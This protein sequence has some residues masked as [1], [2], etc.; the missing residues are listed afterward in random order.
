LNPDTLTHTSAIAEAADVPNAHRWQ[1]V[2][3][4]EKGWSE[5]K[6][7]HLVLEGGEQQLLRISDHTA[8]ESKKKAYE[9]LCR[10]QNF[11]LPISKP[12]AFGRCNAGQ[13]VYL[14]FSWLIGEEAET[15]I[16]LLSVA[17]QYRLGYE[18][19]KALFKMH[20]LPIK[21]QL[22]NWEDKFNQKI[23]RN[24]QRYRNCSVQF[25]HAD[26][27]IHFLNENR[28]LLHARPVS[29]Q[30]GDFHLGNMLLGD[31]AHI[32]ILDFNR[33]DIGDPWEEFNRITLSAS[34]SPAFASGQIDGYFDGEAPELFFRLMAL[35]IGANQLSSI[36]WAIP[37]GEA[38]VAFMLQQVKQVL[39]SYNNFASYMPKWYHT[40]G[41]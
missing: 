25:E 18:A 1:K 8:Y 5:D 31:T 24:I 21:G 6:K 9:M 38:D 39:F 10:L 26:S 12:L 35:Y 30:H 17:E 4:V 14:L 29:F 36:P 41:Y 27:I 40:G 15:A 20:Q 3:P 19:G 34:V 28:H 2:T 7:Y 13:S 23:D 11:S 33:L 32:E 22:I 37:Y 16:P